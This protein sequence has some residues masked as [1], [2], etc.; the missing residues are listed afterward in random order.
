MV[1]SDYTISHDLVY[2]NFTVQSM[3]QDQSLI[4]LSAVFHDDLGSLESHPSWVPR[5]NDPHL[6]VSFGLRAGFEVDMSTVTRDQLVIALEGGNLRT[7]G[8]IFDTIHLSSR[9]FVVDDF[10]SYQ[11]SWRKPK[12]WF[13]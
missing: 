1:E 13:D 6:V 8:I 7:S 5:W 3:M 12:A 9:W 11:Q 4:F 10:K 2:K